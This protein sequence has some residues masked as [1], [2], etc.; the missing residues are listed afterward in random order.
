M[1]SHQ[2]VVPVIH[3]PKSISDG[4]L[5]RLRACYNPLSN[6]VAELDGERMTRSRTKPPLISLALLL[7]DFAAA[8]IAVSSNRFKWR[9]KRV[10]AKG[11]NAFLSLLGLAQTPTDPVRRSLSDREEVKRR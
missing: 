2:I 3:A 11:T 10:Y 9:S 7:R 5:L 6:S 1:D 8:T 4:P